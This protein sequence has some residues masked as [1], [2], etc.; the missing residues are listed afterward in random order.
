MVLFTDHHD[1]PIG[2][3]TVAHRPAPNL[4]RTNDMILSTLDLD[5]RNISLLNVSR[6]TR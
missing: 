2:Q 3:L 5:R 1:Q 6:R 4:E